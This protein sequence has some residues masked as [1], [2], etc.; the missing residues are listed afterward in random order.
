RRVEGNTGV[1][2][3]RLFE[4]ESYRALPPAFT[5]LE[6]RIARSDIAVKLID[7]SPHLTAPGQLGRRGNFELRLI[8]V[9]EESEEL[10]I[11]ALRERIVL[12]V[13]ALG[14]SDR[15][16]QKDRARGIDPVHDRLDAELLDVDPAFLVD[17]G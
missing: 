9:V 16:S 17:L 15:Q 2:V 12:V 7:L 13:V 3:L 5:F 11:V 8:D 14:A 6:I 1:G 4:I 10:V